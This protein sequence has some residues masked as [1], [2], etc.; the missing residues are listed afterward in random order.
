MLRHYCRGAS[1]GPN[2]D[3]SSRHRQNEFSDTPFTLSTLPPICLHFTFFHNSSF[4]QHQ[5]CYLHCQ[6]ISERSG[7]LS[8]SR[9]SLE[10]EQWTT[11]CVFNF[12][13]PVSSAAPAWWSASSSPVSLSCWPSCS[14]LLCTAVLGWVSL[15][16]SVNRCFQIS[17]NLKSYQEHK[18]FFFF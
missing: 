5:K 17:I 9:C 7:A 8:G 10:A 12:T 16:L 13:P 15:V 3:R 1:S 18:D 6:R 4:W 11:S 2:R 14:S